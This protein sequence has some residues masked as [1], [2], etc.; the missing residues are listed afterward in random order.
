A[1]KEMAPLARRIDLMTADLF[2]PEDTER[3]CATVLERHGP[4]HV[5]V[6]NVG[7]RRKNIAVEA[8][9]LEEG[10]RLLDLNLTSAFLCTKLVGGAML[11]R[12]S[13]RG[14]HIAAVCGAD[15]PPGRPPRPHPT[16]EAA[17][18]CGREG[19][20][21][22]ARGREGDRAR[23]GGV[24]EGR[25]PPLVPRAA[26]AADRVRGDDPAG[27]PRGAGGDWS[28]GAVPR[29]RRVELHDRVGSDDRRRLHGV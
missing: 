25:Q 19:G 7:G 2:S 22:G 14:S 9:P 20:G 6:N 29:Q 27:P 5:L 10:K 23:A 21:R 13:G 3:M 16:G 24:Y 28:T 18:A 4:V 26:R 12:R 11:P 1:R 8:T 17:A 15:A